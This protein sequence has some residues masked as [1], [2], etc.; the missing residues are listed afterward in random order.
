LYFAV[1]AERRLYMHRALFDLQR[2]SFQVRRQKKGGDFS[3]SGE[4]TMLINYTPPSKNGIT[5][6]AQNLYTRT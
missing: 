1:C 6:L 2:N 4:Y 5:A 3:V